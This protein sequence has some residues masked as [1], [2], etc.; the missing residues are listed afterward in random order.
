M[1]KIQRIAFP[2]A[3]LTIS[4]LLSSVIANGQNLPRERSAVWTLKEIRVFSNMDGNLGSV[5]KERYDKKGGEVEINIK[6]NPYICAGG[7]EVARFT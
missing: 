2:L 4:L 6:S 7:S 3:V 1:N 5:V